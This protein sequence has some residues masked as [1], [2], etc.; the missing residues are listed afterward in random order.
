M[1]DPLSVASGVAG[2]LGLADI[3]FSRVY[4]YAKA[5]KGAESSAQTLANEIRTLAGLLHSLS[6][7]AT[8]LEVGPTVST[9]RLQHVITC[10]QVLLKIDR[11]TREADPSNPDGGKVRSVLKKLKWPFSST[12]TKE[13]IEEINRHQ[14]VITVAL[15]ADS[16]THLQQLLSG[17]DELRSGQDDLRAGI[18]ALREDFNEQREIETRIAL[19]AKRKEVLQFFGSVDPTE[20]HE[21]SKGLRHRETGSWLLSNTAF[22]AW[23]NHIG[24]RL[25]LSGIPGAGKTILASVV[26][27]EMLRQASGSSEKA[28]AYFYCDYNKPEHQKSS[29]ILGAIACQLARQDKSE[30]SFELLQDYYRSCSPSTPKASRLLTLVQEMSMSFDAVSIVVD[31]L[32]ECGNDRTV[33][34]ED[35]ASL[36]KGIGSNIRTA[37][38]SRAEPDIK[39]ILDNF[40]HIPIAAHNDDVKIFVAE[41]I[42]SRARKG[43]LRI[44]TPGLKNEIIEALINGADGM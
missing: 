38:L 41:E 44:K 34:A 11:K 9:F 32:D 43:N 5:V 24:S 25:W 4:K 17:Q 21:T 19:D 13:L 22:I 16:I 39:N 20:K 12:E 3:V 14:R 37:F 26:I 36:N 35:L 23:A 30:R 28:V 27:E 29:N 18:R 7:V 2:L 33:T 40:M 6:M 10:Q 15:S 1:G 31:A 8:E 42:E